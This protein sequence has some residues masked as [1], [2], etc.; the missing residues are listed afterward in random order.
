[1]CQLH[2]QRIQNILDTKEYT[3]HTNSS[4]SHKRIL[5]NV[6][7]RKHQNVCSFV[8]S[9]VYNFIHIHLIYTF[10]ASKNEQFFNIIT[11]YIL[12]IKLWI[13]TTSLSIHIV[14]KKCHFPLYC[15][16]LFY[17]I[18]KQ[19]YKYAHKFLCKKKING[20]PLKCTKKCIFFNYILFS[21]LY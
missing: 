14:I 13:N 18:N 3:L 7:H 17:N 2:N 19:P 16:F 11:T 1:M 21:F 20:Q 15:F 4:W 12:F 9:I 10:H 8:A 6:I 5:H